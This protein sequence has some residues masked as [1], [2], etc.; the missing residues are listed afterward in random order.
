MVLL[1]AFVVFQNSCIK[2]QG[3]LP[4]AK[5]VNVCTVAVSYSVDIVPIMT[6]NCSTKGCHT[7]TGTGKGDFTNYAG[8]A[9]KADAPVGNGSIRARA[10]N[11][12]PSWM[13]TGGPIADSLRQKI[14]CWLQQGA[15]NN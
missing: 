15:Q 14:D 6:N 13:P 3:E 11:G 4:Q 10:L 1:L 5:K 2:D 9:S 12:N 7:S 8:V